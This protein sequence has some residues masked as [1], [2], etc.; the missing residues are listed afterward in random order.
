[1]RGTFGFVVVS[2]ALQAATAY[3]QAPVPL[4]RPMEQYAPLQSK[5]AEQTAAAPQAQAPMPGPQS[6]P[7]PVGKDRFGNIVRGSTCADHWSNCAYDP[8]RPHP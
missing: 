5:V 6:A 3:A 2:I 4:N 7:A 1:M 8:S